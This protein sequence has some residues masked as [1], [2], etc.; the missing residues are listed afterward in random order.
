VSEL[1]AFVREHTRDGDYLARNLSRICEKYLGS[2]LYVNIMMLGFAFQ[3]G[4]IP[5]SMHSMAWAIKDTIRSE[6]R[7]NLYAFNMGR[8]LVEDRDL[9]LGPPQRTDWRN[10]LEDKWR[11]TVRR[12]RAGQKRADPLRALTAE[13][14]DKC[15]DLDEKS[16]RDVVVRLYDCLRWGGIDYARQYADAVA[17]V[18][19]RDAAARGYQATH[20][21][22]LNLAQAMLIKDGVF[23]A[24]LATSP[25]KYQR[26]RE[27]YNV[28]AANGD[29]IVYRHLWTG[30]LRLGPL[31]PRRYRLSL[32]CRTLR[33]L[34]RMRWLRK[35]LPNWH[36]PERRHL[37]QYRRLVAE[38]RYADDAEYRRQVALLSGSGCMDCLCPRCQEA[39]CPLES[40]A[41]R[42]IRLA[43]EQ[44]WREACESLHAA[45]N[46][47][48]FTAALCPAPCQSACKQAI[49]TY[50][51]PIRH[52]EAQIVAR[53][54]A[55]GWITPHPPQTKTG[56][57]V[58][59]VGSGPA[60]LAAAQ[61]LARAG[62]NVTVFEKADAPG[63]LLRYGVPDFRLEKTLLDRRLEQLKAEGVAF[64]T[65][66]AVG[67]DTPADALRRDFDAVLLAVG[68]AQPRDLPVPGRKTPGIHF[69]LDFLRQENLRRAGAAVPADQ[70]I[71]A[72]GK[73]VAVIGGG[74]TGNDCVETAL[75]QGASAVCQLE[76]LDEADINGDLMHARPAGVRRLYRAATR[77]FCQEDG[78]LA[79]LAAATVRWVKTTE[80]ARMVDVPD[81]EFTIEADLALLALGFEPRLESALIEQL[82]LRTDPA[83]R[84]VAADYATNVPGVFISGDAATGPAL[85]ATAIHSGRKAAQRI[86]QFLK[87]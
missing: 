32:S 51:V 63:G 46:F 54:F 39:G 37:R 28:N 44:R 20:A 38:F 84:V 70:A 74:E 11:W 34:K 16:K 14:I 86:N 65:G 53:A 73:K 19:A 79:G 30:T 29:R 50:P 2:K 76:V 21:V 85:I 81:S 17:G 6:F 25:E 59:V 60:G 52:I 61:Q 12:Y 83:G 24:E 35:L 45:N 27:K 62:H 56:K 41:P 68:A 66:A 42:W 23:L 78:R 57:K 8:K 77:R 58:A 55:E 3:K 7:K 69:A 47:P 87:S 36:R 1:E 22:I 67:T 49:N 48:E 10:A 9:F 64:R 26:D 18:Y 33:I 75:A 13:T 40:R 71:S 72:A 82:G 5:V 31:P 4:L 80:G 43:N 15:R